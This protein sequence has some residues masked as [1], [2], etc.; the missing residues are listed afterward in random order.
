MFTRELVSNVELELGVG[1]KF[2]STVGL[3]LLDCV[4][5]VVKL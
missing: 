4:A 5:D 3:E 2:A 1:R